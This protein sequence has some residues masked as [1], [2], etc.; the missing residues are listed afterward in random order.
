MLSSMYY[1]AS[2]P[3]LPSQLFSQPWQKACFCHGCEKSCEGRPGYEAMYY[4][5]GIHFNE[6]TGFYQLGAVYRI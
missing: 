1:I 2:Y 4:I 6:N 5:L 3:G